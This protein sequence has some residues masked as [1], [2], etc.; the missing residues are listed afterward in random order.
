MLKLE[1][2]FSKEG[3]HPFDEVQWS[4]RHIDIPG[5]NEAVDVEFPTFWS[6]NAVVITASKYFKIL[7]GQTN[8]EYSLK[9]LIKRAVDQITK[10]GLEFG[11]F[12]EENSEVFDKD[13]KWLLLHQEFAF[14]SP[15]WFNSGFPNPQFSACF[16]LGVE[17]SIESMLE[18]QNAEVRLFKQGSGAGTNYGKVRGKGE[19]VSRGG[20][21]SGAVSFMS[22]PDAWAGTIRSGG[23]TRRA[24]K[25]FTLD[26][27]HPD[28]EQFITIKAEEEEKAK[29][30]IK[31]GWESGM[32][33]KVY[34]RLQFQNSNFSV[35][36]TDEFMS[37][38]NKGRTFKLKER[39]TDKVREVNARELLNKIA[40]SAWG[41]G[42]PGLQFSDTINAAHPCL[43][44]AGRIRSSN[45]CFA[46]G[47]RLVTPSGL[48]PIKELCE[49][50]L[51]GIMSP[52]ITDG[53]LISTP[54]AYM[55]TG[56]QPIFQVELSDGRV[57]S[58]SPNHTWVDWRTG[59]KVTTEHLKGGELV[60]ILRS[61]KNYQGNG[62]FPAD[63]TLQSY[64]VRGGR[65]ILPSYLPKTWDPSFAQL[66]GHFV[67]DGWMSKTDYCIGWV[68]G[69]KNGED[70]TYADW[71]VKKLNEWFQGYNI[72]D[73]IVE[74]GCRSVRISRGVIQNLFIDLGCDWN[75]GL[76]KHVPES[77][78]R[79]PKQ[80]IASFLSGYFGAD[81]TVYGD[82][83]EGSVSIN[84]SSISLQL[85]RD[86]QLLL[87]IFGITSY[88][89]LV[90]GAGEVHFKQDDKTYKTN[91]T[92]R[93]SIDT[94]SIDIFIKEIGIGVPQKQERALHLLSCRK[95]TKKR[96]R[97][98]IT[99]LKVTDTGRSEPVYNL[100]EPINHLVYA[101]G[102][103][104]P[105]CSEFLFI[106]H[107]A[108]NLASVKL[109]AEGNPIDMNRLESIVHL[110]IIAMD[111]IVDGATYPTEKIRENSI[112]YRPLGLGISNLGAHLMSCGIPYDSDEGR[113]IAKSIVKGLTSFATKTSK[114]LATIKGPYLPDKKVRNAQVTLAA[115][116]GCLA[117][118]TLI[119][120]SQG[121]LPISFLG[122][123]D[124]EE[125]QEIN[126]VVHKDF[127]NS[128][129]SKFF[130]NGEEIVYKTTTKHGRS[131]ESTGKHKFRVL[132]FN[133]DYIWKEVNFLEKGDLIA[134][135]VGGHEI[136][137]GKK[138]L[139]KLDNSVLR[140]LT[141]HHNQI[142]LPEV[143]DENF[144]EILG[145]Y[146][147][148]GYI[149]DTGGICL[150][151]DNQSLDLINTFKKFAD[152]I[153]TSLLREPNRGCEKITISSYLF[154]EWFENNNF[155]KP[156]GNHGEGAAGAFIPP[157]IL[158]SRTS[159]LCAFLR[160]LFEADGTIAFSKTGAEVSLSTVSSLLANQVACAL[161]SIGI[162]SKIEE[163]EEFDQ[164][165]FGERKR[166]RV[167][168]ALKKFHPIYAQKIGFLSERKKAKALEIEATDQS[169]T[170]YNQ[171][172]LN[173]I[174]EIAQEDIKWDVKIRAREGHFN[175]RW[176]INLLD[177]YQYF[178]AEPHLN[179]LYNL[180]KAGIFFDE[181][182]S[183]EISGIKPTFD[184][185]V[186]DNHTYIANGFVTHNTIGFMMDCDTTGIEPDF[187]LN[188]E[189]VLAGGG[190]LKQT[191]GALL[192][193][194][195]GLLKAKLIDS[196]VMEGTIKWIESN[197]TI[198]GSPLPK[199]LQPIFY[200]ATEISPDGHLEMMAI[201]QPHLSGGISK[202]INVS[203]ST[204]PEQIV[205][206]FNKAWK[207]GLKSITIYRNNSKGIQ[208]LKV[209]G[210]E[211]PSPKP[212]QKFGLPR[213]RD[214][215]IIKFNI[216]GSEGYVTLGYY[217]DG[218]IGDVFLTMSKGG[219]SINGWAQAVGI[220]TSTALQH[221]VTPE[222]LVEKLSYIQF[223]PAGV[224]GDK[225]VPIVTSPV[226]YLARKL[227]AILHVEKDN[228]VE[229]IIQPQETGISCPT[230]GAIMIRAGS[231]YTCKICG[232]SS[233]CSG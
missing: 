224:T 90:K 11:Y 193:G 213:E 205:Q 19:P 26:I 105:Q 210:V 107:S 57:L 130:V 131:I 58:V 84:C 141:K 203:E 148:D 63:V 111:I 38:A 3:V 94:E 43:E 138:E 154:S 191:S 177:K 156:K 178:K 125:W 180:L 70:T 75:D 4:F 147:G 128:S 126:L 181:V 112:K 118:D 13:L 197:G 187:A 157:L 206:I 231:C 97:F 29:F 223:D 103:L 222:T 74:N 6:N 86:I 209:K 62:T 228:R 232:S 79:A 202:T 124:G 36:V 183:I 102:I 66:L 211:F 95:H 161:D 85:L 144:A 34:G 55:S 71:A 227:K 109:Q 153:G 215:K 212:S 12:D 120:T 146:M 195:E 155:K 119:L 37:A 108:C 46:A 113:S 56:I 31:N 1:R 91:A 50:S 134:R 152:S 114:E 65:D 194:L 80:I 54:V 143:L 150:I 139:E 73:A 145:Y 87:D 201:I 27:D 78:F 45:P 220:L 208:P 92:Y 170:I 116:C 158:K 192:K 135:S 123:P 104:I 5:T 30:L 40:Q 44:E 167:S 173:I 106:D 25:L 7:P 81:G 110:A 60:R 189:K 98:K 207:L 77:I 165:H 67:G 168:V 216:A 22:G 20:I 172:V 129:A 48:I 100:T 69:T 142:K 226:D 198:I 52:V 218:Y 99:V 221:G 175:E 82:E 10:W 174:N 42:D 24:A 151:V 18:L 93:L 96:D 159:I 199:N 15:V 59:K 179:N 33:G 49:K 121:L 204:T 39:T 35:M 72:Q 68:F 164:N 133:G 28:I 186:P 163:R 233:G 32:E 214:G 185:E 9:Q 176:F 219:S 115:P 149:K 2:K 101:N 140:K 89:S 171:G 182:L 41:C 190:T 137:L 230:C 188:K 184:L 51:D 127:G 136:L 225:E 53:D 217:P 162:P 16:I 117:G 61:T 166:F 122:V 132:D 8:R 76:D 229:K 47:T 169:F 196:N 64:Q 200:C 23:A 160:G 21:A 88:I 17:D 83:K 14:N